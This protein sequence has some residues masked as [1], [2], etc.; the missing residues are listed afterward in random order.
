MMNGDGDAR[1]TGSF[2][3]GAKVRMGDWFDGQASGAQRV[4]AF[5]GFGRDVTSEP[6][7]SA[8]PVHTFRS[9]A[10]ERKRKPEECI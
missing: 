7:A 5:V 9:I 3:V 2:D 10:M 1:V 6:E 8:D 4:L